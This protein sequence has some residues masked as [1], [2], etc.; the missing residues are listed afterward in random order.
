VSGFGPGFGFGPGPPGPGT[1]SG[2]G[3][4]VGGGIRGGGIRTP[5]AAGAPNIAVIQSAMLKDTDDKASNLPQIIPPGRM[6]NG[7]RTPLLSVLVLVVV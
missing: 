7:T 1:G 2:N 6:M 3:T 5:P 4:G